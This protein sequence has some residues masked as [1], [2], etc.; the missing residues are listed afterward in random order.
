MSKYFSH[1]LKHSKSNLILQYYVRFGHIKK[2]LFVFISFL[3]FAAWNWN[4]WLQKSGNGVGQSEQILKFIDFQ[5]FPVFPTTYLHK[6]TTISQKTFEFVLVRLL[7]VAKSLC[8]RW[9][10]IKSRASSTLIEVQ[11]YCGSLDCAV[12]LQ[13]RC[14]QLQYCWTVWIEY[15]YDLLDNSVGLCCY[16]IAHHQV[17][18]TV[19]QQEGRLRHFINTLLDSFVM[20]LQIRRVFTSVP[21]QEEMGIA[22][23]ALDGR[24]CRKRF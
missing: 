11:L 2:F 9:C 20:I 6:L 19:P 17:A 7:P 12:S 14:N 15:C 3:V 24:K 16:N 23:T 21:L 5:L 13:Y 1:F 22:W 4:P 8:Q 18:A 10:K